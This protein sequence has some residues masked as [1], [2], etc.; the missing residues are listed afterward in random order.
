MPDRFSATK[1]G[2]ALLAAGAVAVAAVA[3]K[4][5]TGVPAGLETVADSG[6]VYAING[7]PSGAP[8]AVHFYTGSR[9]AADA[10][11]FFDI[12]FD[13]DSTGHVLLLPQRTVASG[14][15]TTHAV[16]LLSSTQAYADIQQAPTSGYRADTAMVVVPNQS[17]LVQ[18]QDP[19]CAASITG[20]FIYG[21]IVVLSADAVARTLDVQYVGD[22]NCG[23]LSFAP[24]I[25]KN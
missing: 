10:S 14:L 4:S 2:A 25:P 18:V 9:T 21:K 13:I 23:F 6:T 8:T 17:I 3:C 19:A 1:R 15:T 12:A 24:G 20:T 7:A 5:L 11:F 16:G 22:P